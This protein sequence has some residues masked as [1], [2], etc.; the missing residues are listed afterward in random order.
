MW[1]NSSPIFSLGQSL[2]PSQLDSIPP[3]KIHI[4]RLSQL[5]NLLS[6]L[7]I[8]LSQL[9]I[10]LSQLDILLSQLDILTLT[11]RLDPSN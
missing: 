3:T 9:D 7:D 11:T 6:Q 5:D 4:R 10:L 8:L 1:F 2:E